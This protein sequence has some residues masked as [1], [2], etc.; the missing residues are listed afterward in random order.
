ML[1]Y[2]IQS[3]L[4]YQHKLAV[5]AVI[6]QVGT[7]IRFMCMNLITT[8]TELCY[9]RLCCNKRFSYSVA[10]KFQCPSRKNALAINSNIYNLALKYFD[11]SVKAVFALNST[12]LSC[13]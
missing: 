5:Q 2:H 9:N 6:N 12:V 3:V 11:T 7:F 1:L 8:I 4:L 10:H 13:Q